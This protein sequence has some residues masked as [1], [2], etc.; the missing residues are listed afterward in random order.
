[1]CMARRLH[2]PRPAEIL[3]SRDHR[4]FSPAMSAPVLWQ[5]MTWEEI[6]R[7]R[8][9]GGGIVLL[10]VGAT[11]QHGPHLATSVDSV[12]AE[13]LAHAASAATGIPVLP[14]LHYGC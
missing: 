6:A 2:R 9:S 13:R 12:T 4:H 5:S 7:L 1:G 8:E 11:E 3:P 14:T 10:P